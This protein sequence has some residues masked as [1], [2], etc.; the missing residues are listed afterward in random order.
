MNVLA[1]LL[2]LTLLAGEPR[3]LVLKSG[4]LIFV[5]G[6]ITERG[7]QLLFRSAGTLY[8]LPLEEIDIEAT[9]R[10]IQRDREIAERMAK[11]DK[12]AR[13]KVTPAERDRLLAEL[14]KSEGKPSPPKPAATPAPPPPPVAAPAPP[15]TDEPSP[16]E[17][18][19]EERYW[20]E[21][22]RSHEEAVRRQKE[23]IAF[24]KNR[25]QKLEDEILQLLSLGY[26]S[27]QFSREVL[28]LERT[29]DDLE[30]AELD[31]VRVERALQQFYED[32][33]REG[34]LPG[35]LR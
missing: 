1:S 32:A 5:D 30:R 29:R 15:A 2:M 25:E 3:A 7:S 24:L 17:L 12:V 4:D 6:A 35:W 19:R 22:A 10:K 16:E 11:A 33:R 28:Q 20:R 18:K 23:E 13:L 34:I 27:N 8:S 26:T 9:N 31:L 14:K 21:R